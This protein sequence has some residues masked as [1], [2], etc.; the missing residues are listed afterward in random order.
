MRF[1]NVTA[2]KARSILDDDLDHD[3]WN[4]RFSDEDPFASAEVQEQPLLFPAG[5]S[6]LWR[7]LRCIVVCLEE[8]EHE[9]NLS[10]EMSSRMKEMLDRLV[11]DELELLVELEKITKAELIKEFVM[12]RL[13]RLLERRTVVQEEFELVKQCID[14]LQSEVAIRAGLDQVLIILRQTSTSIEAISRDCQ[15]WRLYLASYSHFPVNWLIMNFIEVT[16]VIFASSPSLAGLETI[17]AFLPLYQQT[18]LTLSSP[19][20]S[21]FLMATIV[22]VLMN[23]SSWLDALSTALLNSLE[24]VLRILVEELGERVVEVVLRIIVRMSVNGNSDNSKLS[25]FFS[26]L[27]KKYGKVVK[28]VTV[29]LSESEKEVV[30]SLLNKSLRVE[31]LR[32]QKT[33]RKAVRQQLVIDVSKM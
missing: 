23:T 5:G 6:R 2:E 13:V 22:N 29:Q 28:E 19:H 10:A 25:T 32:E 31:T 27:V 15:F 9:M 26:E 16:L 17:Q 14:N 18:L 8:E 24:E 4:P 30:K 12:M 20:R 11:R 7:L 33:K 21:Q 3:S 1:L